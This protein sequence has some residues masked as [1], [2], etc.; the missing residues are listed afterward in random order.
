MVQTIGRS[1]KNELRSASLEAF[2]GVDLFLNCG[3]LQS[4]FDKPPEED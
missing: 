1:R 4:V 3:R 2:D